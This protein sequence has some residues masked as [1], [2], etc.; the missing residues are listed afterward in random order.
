MIT[1]NHHADGSSYIFTTI[2]WTKKCVRRA[3]FSTKRNIMVASKEG[4]FLSNKREIRDC[5][6]CQLPRSK[7]ISHD[8]G[9][10]PEKD[11]SFWVQWDG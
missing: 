8:G 11:S 1:E 2:H 5:L 9:L 10:N 3:Y 6:L 7:P 4:Y